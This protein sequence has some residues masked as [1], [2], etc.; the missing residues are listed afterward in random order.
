M[1]HLGGNLRSLGGPF[2]AVPRGGAF[3]LPTRSVAIQDTVSDFRTS[4]T[5]TRL[6]VD[7]DNSLDSHG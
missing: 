2:L 3:R 4:A 7:R 1:S 6:L 5:F